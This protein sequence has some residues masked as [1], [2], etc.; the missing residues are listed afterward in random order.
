[1]SQLMEA[2]VP[3][4]GSDQGVP[5]IELL[6]KVGDVVTKDQGLVTLESDKA[7]MEVEAV[8]EGVEQG[9]RAVLPHGQLDE[10]VGVAQQVCP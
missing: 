2:R 10:D 9:V 4:I 1:M 5:V 7:T 6:V 8:D 3:D